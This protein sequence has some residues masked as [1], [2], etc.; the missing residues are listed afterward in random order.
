MLAS[1]AKFSNGR[2]MTKD[3]R[4]VIEI[5][6]ETGNTAINNTVIPKQEA[7][8]PIQGE[9][10]KGYRIVTDVETGEFDVYSTGG[11]KVAHTTTK[12]LA[13]SYIDNIDTGI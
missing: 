12:E 1:K 8:T 9:N 7:E 4:I 2:M 5:D 11:A 10:Y 3:A 6:T 13:E